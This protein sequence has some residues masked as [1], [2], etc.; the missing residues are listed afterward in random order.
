VALAGIDYE[1]RGKREQKGQGILAI[2]PLPPTQNAMISLPCDE[3]RN[4]TAD[5][6]KRCLCKVWNS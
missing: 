6:V 5:D 4:Q 1:Y 3:E 2:T